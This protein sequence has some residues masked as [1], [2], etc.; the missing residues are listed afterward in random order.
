MDK[1][2]RLL[3]Q[4]LKDNNLIDES[5]IREALAIQKEKGGAIGK[6]FVDM[7]WI[8]EDE[9][10]QALG[11]QFGMDS[12][13]L[14][15]LDISPDV[16]NKVPVSMAN[17]YRVVP[18]SF[19]D[20]LLI[21]AMAD[22]MNVQILDD[23]RLMLHCEVQGAV[24]NE[25]Q[26][27]RSIEK[28][29]ADAGKETIDSLLGELAEEQ[30]G[31]EIIEKKDSYDLDDASKMAESP[32]VIKLLNLILMQAIKDKGSDVHF[33]PF[34]RDFKIRYRVDGVLYEMM[35]PPPHLAM[36]LISRIKVMSNL[37]IAETR[38]PQDGRIELT[39][40]GRPVDLRVSTLPTMFGESCV[41]RILDR[42]V[43]NLD[44]E[45]VG[46]RE[47]ELEIMRKFIAKPN[48]IVLVTGPTGSGKTTTLYSALSEANTI[49]IK[50]ITTE[51]PVEYD[52]E[53]IMQCQV[54]EEVG[55][56][57][58]AALRSIL[59]QDPDKVLVGEIRDRETA[60]IAVEAALTG[61]LV[62]STLHTND[63]P[64]SVARLIDMGIEP[65][66][67][68]ATLE[69]IIAQRLVRRI[70]A[71]C[72]VEYEPQLEEVLELGLQPEDLGGKR[73]A[74]GKGCN[75]CNK[76]G[77][78]GRTA[79]FE[80]M[81]FT[82]ELRQL[83]LEQASTGQLRELAREQGMRTLRESGLLAIFDA[84]TSIEEVVRET[85]F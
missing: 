83:V 59:R 28:Y 42:T 43:V 41:M 67:I 85:L 53:G 25:D 30:D 37:D 27:Q 10:L 29:Y 75:N 14:D 63:A 72:K 1:P 58:A 5:Q 82:D 34:E 3:G 65:F 70:C 54:N 73:F 46:L 45:C 39:I 81:I 9:V 16:I 33:E 51:D 50:I 80:I 68:A 35:P 69:G 26:I 76:S 19:K 40:G 21:I 13:N 4:I 60:G 44:L 2:H 20:G 49:D 62:F 12:V 57:Y 55:L 17:I 64:G 52:I 23:L 77:Y 8:T 36:A 71:N 48:G 78:R 79:L 18:V 11:E 31:V 47:R 24:S 32:P 38:L 56:T 66:L 15:D 84:V 7:G 22:P 74:Y 61:H 6:I